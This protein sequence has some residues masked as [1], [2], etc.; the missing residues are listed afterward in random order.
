MLRLANTR[1]RIIGE[2]SHRRVCRTNQTIISYG[3]SSDHEGVPQHIRPYTPPRERP[4][5]IKTAHPS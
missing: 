4:G 5:A 1:T 2:V 3:P